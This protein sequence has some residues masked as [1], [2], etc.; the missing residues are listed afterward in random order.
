MES[1]NMRTSTRHPLVWVPSLYFAQGLPF[2][3]VA[4]MASIMYKKLGMSNE[5][6]AYWTGLLGFAWVF[7]PLWSPL[8]EMAGS[9]K[10]LVVI[11]QILGGVAMLAVALS[12]RQPGFFTFSIG[13][14]SLVAFA[15]ATHDIASDGSYICNLSQQ[16]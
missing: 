9:K 8:L 5:D 3:V 4:I 10:K 12:L 14:L 6:I 16:Q 11:F 1:D 2:A 13:L 15:S 7:K